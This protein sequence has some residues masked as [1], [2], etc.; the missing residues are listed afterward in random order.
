MYPPQ[1]R[2]GV[3]RHVEEK[4]RLPSPVLTGSRFEGLRSPALSAQRGALPCRVL[5]AILPPLPRGPRWLLPH[6]PAALPRALGPPPSAA[7][8]A[9]R[10]APR[11]A[12]CCSTRPRRQLSAFLE[13][14]RRCALG[15]A[16]SAGSALERAGDGPSY[17]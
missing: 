4:A 17:L 16:Y 5:P 6:A 9:L 11:P 10:C 1:G 2:E 15:A 12:S 3:F 8:S 13:R 7:R 14:I